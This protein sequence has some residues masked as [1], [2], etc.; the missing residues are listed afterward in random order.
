MTDK[1]II[2]DLETKRT[3]EEVGGRNAL[4]KLGIS[5]V[6]VYQYE[7]DTYSTFLEKDF[8]ALQNL[9]IDASL[10]VG[11][12]HVYFDMPVLQPY[13]S[14]DVKKLPCFDIMLDLQKIIGHRIGLDAVA[15]A[16]LG[17]GKIAT[18]LDAIRFYQEGRWDELKKY[19]LKD[20]EVTKEVFEYGIKNGQV[21]F[22]SRF[23]P[24]I[25]EVKVK[26]TPYNKRQATKTMSENPAEPAQYKLF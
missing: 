25:K 5:V 3:F 10:I 1:R 8:G 14:V 4:D 13:L 6:G 11:F 7:T 2:L 16:T 26:W 24:A 22:R 19:C 18:G 15:Q 23:G 9:L 17:V 21:M 12:N 20:V